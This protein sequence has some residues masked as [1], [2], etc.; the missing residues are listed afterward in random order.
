MLTH[1]QIPALKNNG[2]K[3]TGNPL[4]PANIQQKSLS[5]TSNQPGLFPDRSLLNHWPRLKLAG[6]GKSE[7]KSGD[8]AIIN[9]KKVHL[10][11]TIAGKVRLVEIR[12]HDV[13]VEFNGEKRI[14][15][16]EN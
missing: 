5:E 10:E 13:I 16:I 4:F 9:G 6:F 15:T 3:T 7:E 11:Q 1:Y 2:I 14:L 12:D 8:F